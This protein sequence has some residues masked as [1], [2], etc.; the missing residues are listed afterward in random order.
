MA[1]FLAARPRRDADPDEFSELSAGILR[2]LIPGDYCVLP[3]PGPE[4]G[5]VPGASQCILMLHEK[6]IFVFLYIRQF[7]LI[8]GDIWKNTWTS[9]NIMGEQTFFASP[10]MRNRE[11]IRVL[12][13]IL[14]LP[15]DRFHSCIVFN[16]ECD[17]RKA[18][19]SSLLSVIHIEQLE[20]HFD[21]LLPTL[22]LQ[23]THTQ[24]EALRD[25]FLCVTTNGRAIQQQ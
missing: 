1:K 7:G 8:H 25:I 20:N 15:E 4:G 10:Y 21:R 12:S 13:Q 5:S 18:P 23:Y 16:T 19:K 9:T 6:G 14:K 3:I 24:L 17:I 11:N 22:P 2:T